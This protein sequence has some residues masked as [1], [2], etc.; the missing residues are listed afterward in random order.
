MGRWG[1]VLGLTAAAVLSFAC[2]PAAP[3]GL[4]TTIL[5]REIGQRIGGPSTCVLV[6]EPGSGKIVYRYGLSTACERALPT[7]QGPAT[8]TVQDLLNG[9]AAPAEAVTRSCPTTSDGSRSVGWSAGPVAGRDLVFA[10]VMEGERALPGR[11]MTD[12]LAG[13]FTAAGLD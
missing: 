7:C 3:E 2:A 9:L 5:D 1:A 6:A 12:R 11:V 13:A 8:E 4:D 10:A